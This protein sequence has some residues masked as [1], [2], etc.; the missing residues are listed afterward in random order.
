MLGGISERLALWA[1]R[2]RRLLFAVTVVLYALGVAAWI[3]LP[4]PRDFA[5]DLPAT[6]PVAR[7]R[8]AQR[9]DPLLRV[10]VSPIDAVQAAAVAPGLEAALR[11]SPVVADV[12]ARTAAADGSARAL[13]DAR[14]V[15]DQLPPLG[16]LLSVPRDASLA[17]ALTLVAQLPDAAGAARIIEALQAVVIAGKG[18][19]PDGLNVALHA[20]VRWPVGAAGAGDAWRVRD[21]GL[22]VWVRARPDVPLE[23]LEPALQP[24][25]EGLRARGLQVAVDGY[26]LRLRSPA[27]PRWHGVFAALPLGVAAGLAW[28][29]G[30][31]L[32]PVLV[33][34]VAAGGLL[35]LPLLVLIFLGAGLDPAATWA[36]CVAGGLLGAILLAYHGLRLGRQGGADPPLRLVRRVLRDTVLSAGLVSLLCLLAAAGTRWAAPAASGVLAGT[37]F[38]V[39]VFWALLL[40][41]VDL[42]HN[43]VNL[44]ASVPLRHLTWAPD[45]R[46][47]TGVALLLGLIAFAGLREAPA[48]PATPPPLEGDLPLVLPVAPVDASA[49]AVRLRSHP[50]VLRAEG[51]AVPPDATARA[52]LVEDAAPVLSV[53][54]PAGAGGAVPDEA[55]ATAA[56]APALRG[57]A[58]QTPALARP[59]GALA[60][61]LSRG[62]AEARPMHAYLASGAFH[63][64]LDRLRD[65]LRAVIERGTRAEA[66]SDF[67]RPT[68]ERAL[69]VV[70]PASGALLP[71]IAHPLDTFATV[72]EAPAVSGLTWATALFG[73]FILGFVG[74][75]A[76]GGRLFLLAIPPLAAAIPV[77][78][79]SALLGVP[80]ATL[81]TS[82]A[83]ASG[84]VATLFVSVVLRLRSGAPGPRGLRAAV[85]GALLVGLLAGSFVV[86]GTP[87]S[88]PA[89]ATVLTAA[90]VMAIVYLTG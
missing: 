47:F 27:S 35:A 74:L 63:H 6:H 10:R 41:A 53:L 29:L 12:S 49:L 11:T 22:D 9:A 88:A 78:R 84:I 23:A 83:W 43:P 80:V 56:L 57:L 75:I 38:A 34:S 44:R 42:T 3:R 32:V 25:L 81:N 69:V 76:A 77:L 28:A 54:P 89:A 48:V 17:D 2:R 73:V 26:P 60:E 70:V 87:F 24:V 55:P 37:A 68:P 90:L 30:A 71:G 61:H 20:L 45:V 82:A 67:F 16:A 8:Q 39:P 4:R 50:D 36:L 86:R 79:S 51:P 58:D 65:D 40:P 72:R 33:S 64:A 46:F 31:P 21:G 15:V 13:Q 52:R 85:G 59:L 62:P 18:A 1:A 14:H 66:T 19:P 5:A 7:A